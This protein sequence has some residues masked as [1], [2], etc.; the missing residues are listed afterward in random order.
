M[1][2]NA[3]PVFSHEYFM[4]KALELAH[5]AYENNEVPVGALVVADGKKIIGKG[6]NQTEQLNDVTAHAEIL[7]ITAASNFLGAKYLKNCTLY[8]TLE[9]CVMCAGAIAWAQ[10]DRV[11]YAAK[12]I[13]KGYSKYSPAIIHPKYDI[14]PG[15]LQ[16]ESEHLLKIFF[17]RLRDT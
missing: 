15:I 3:Y 5:Q 9:P 14:V 16:N 6:F 13:K 1:A 17:K 8:I 2:R 11:V 12:D 7:A 10:I 4:T